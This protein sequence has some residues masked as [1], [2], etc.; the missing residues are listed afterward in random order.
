LKLI[1]LHQ[2]WK[3]PVCKG[4]NVKPEFVPPVTDKIIHSNS[5]LRNQWLIAREQLLDVTELVFIGYSFPQTDYYTEW[6][7]R[8]LNLRMPKRDV[9]V[10]IVNP[11]Y[12]KR[13]SLVSKRYDKIFK[14]YN[15]KKY[16][17]IKEYANN[18][19]H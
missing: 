5:F 8:Q 2:L 4:I 9:H 14:G 16:S 7:F 3:C 19:N 11:E 13:G 10:T 6:L 1:A 17:T 12:G 15:V 18:A